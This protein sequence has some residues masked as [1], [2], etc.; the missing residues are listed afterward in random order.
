MMEQ[1]ENLPF[2]SD[3]APFRNLPGLGDVFRIAYE[4]SAAGVSI[5]ALSGEYIHANA[6]FCDFVGY[7][8][9]ELRMLGMFDL[10]HPEDRERASELK[11]RLQRGEVVGRI[12]WERR[13]IHKSGQCLWA[14]LTTTLVRDDEGNSGYFLSQV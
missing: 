11:E 4:Q 7:S 10:M 6:A 8:L 2:V 12:R 1:L 14:L 3:E 13:Y 9:G 5:A